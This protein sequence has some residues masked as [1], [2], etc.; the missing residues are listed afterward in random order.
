[1]LAG[2]GGTLRMRAYQMNEH[3]GHA[4]AVWRPFQHVFRAPFT[5]ECVADR[6]FVR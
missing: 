3:A 1:M 5:N 4:L 6:D 2:L